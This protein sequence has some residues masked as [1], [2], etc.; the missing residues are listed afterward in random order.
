MYWSI[1]HLTMHTIH[2]LITP[3]GLHMHV[4]M[5]QVCMYIQNNQWHT[6]VFCCRVSVVPYRWIGSVSKTA[7]LP[8]PSPPPYLI[9]CLS[10]SPKLSPLFMQAEAMEARLSP[11]HSVLLFLFPSLIVLRIRAHNFLFYFSLSLSSQSPRPLLLPILL[12][13]REVIC[14]SIAVSSSSCGYLSCAK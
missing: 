4:C 8:L 10:Q 5:F 3:D 12:K 13:W 11:A 14:S 1:I 7:P 9:L 6:Y 2:W